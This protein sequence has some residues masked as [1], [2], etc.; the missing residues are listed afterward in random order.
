MKD[1]LLGITKGVQVHD[2][3][4]AVS[5]GSR[6][7]LTC[8]S[9]LL[10]FSRIKPNTASVMRLTILSLITSLSVFVELYITQ[11]LLQFSHL[12]LIVFT[13]CLL[14]PPSLIMKLMEETTVCPACDH[15]KRAPLPP[16]FLRLAVPGFKPTT[17]CQ[18]AR[19]APRINICRNHRET[20]KTVS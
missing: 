10:L 5:F 6:F 19:L 3:G 7:A 18:P 1:V 15:I 16:F 17:G 9:P 12:S 11:C 4:P 8:N 13:N 20:A 2:Q 14:G